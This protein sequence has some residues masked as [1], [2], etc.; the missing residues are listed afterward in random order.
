MSLLK[1][2]PFVFDA[3]P[4]GAGKQVRDTSL[5]AYRE[6]QPELPQR[7]REVLA[8][9]LLWPDRTAYELVKLLDAADVNGVRPRLTALQARG[10]VARGIKR[11]CTVTGKTAYTWR[12]TH[13]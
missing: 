3:D 8:A 12:A 1:D 2:H 10:I 13:V 11:E 7:E 5:Q 9:V 6:I 4:L